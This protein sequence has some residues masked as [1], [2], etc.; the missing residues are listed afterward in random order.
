[1][2]ETASPPAEVDT[3]LWDVVQGVELIDI[4]VVRWNSELLDYASN[5]VGKFDPVLD[6]DFR[7]DDET[8]QLRWSFD[9]TLSSATGQ[10]VATLGLTLVQTF[11]F[12]DAIANVELSRELVQRFIAKTAVISIIPFV[13]EAVQTM[14]V[15]LGLPAVTLGLV[16]AGETGPQVFSV[17]GEQR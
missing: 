9:S 6:V 11:A 14:T 16:R 5:S 15:R 12:T 10:E 8:M 4:R 2:T 13:R 1:M 3:D 7:R 17:R